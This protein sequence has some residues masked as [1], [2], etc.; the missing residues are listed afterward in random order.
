MLVLSRGF[1]NFRCLEEHCILAFVNFNGK[2]YGTAVL[3]ALLDVL[4]F[5]AQLER[6]LKQFEKEKKK[7]N[8][9]CV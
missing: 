9:M 6:A 2:L 8:G 7:V 5:C 4:R 3:E 1:R